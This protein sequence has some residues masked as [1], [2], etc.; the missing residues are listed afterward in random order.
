MDTIPSVKSMKAPELRALADLFIEKG[1][2]V[3]GTTAK[4]LAAELTALVE[5]HGFPHR[6]TAQDLEDDP[7]L[8]EGIDGDATHVGDI[9]F[10]ETGDTHADST[11]A[12]DASEDDDAPEAPKHAYY[13]NSPVVR[14]ETRVISGKMYKEV[15]TSEAS[16]LLTEEEYAAEVTYR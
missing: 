9:I 2:A 5:K 8:A 12:N 4:A 6:V 13:K 15:F 7:T 11:P 14:T 16:Y 1:V 10:L 3:T